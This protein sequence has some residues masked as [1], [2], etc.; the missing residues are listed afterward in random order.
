[1]RHKPEH[2]CFPS[3]EYCAA[4]AYELGVQDAKKKPKEA[5]KYVWMVVGSDD[6][7]DIR[8]YAFSHQEAVAQLAHAKKN[9]YKD[10]TGGVWTLFK[11][12]RANKNLC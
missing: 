11:L 5:A 3:R 2:S 1:M 9:K 4:C 12:V 8:R 6:P 7:C 10:Y